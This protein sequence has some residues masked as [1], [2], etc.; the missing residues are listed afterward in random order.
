MGRNLKAG[1]GAATMEKCSPTCSPW[2]AQPFFL[3]SPRALAQGWSQTQWSGPSY[4]SLR[5]HPTGLSKAQDYGA[6]F[7]IEVPFSQMTLV[8][9]VDIKSPSILSFS[10]LVQRSENWQQCLHLMSTRQHWAPNLSSQKKRK[11][12]RGNSSPSIFL[13]CLCS[14]WCR[15]GNQKPLSTTKLQIENLD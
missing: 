6:V 13:F 7:S 15:V 14:E 12:G 1:A 9:Q 11:K 5:K 8:C 10:V 3:Y 4:Q 2:F